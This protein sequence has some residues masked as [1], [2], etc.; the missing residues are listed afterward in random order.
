[1][2]YIK[3]KRQMSYQQLAIL[4]Q[5]ATASFG[6]PLPDS[7]RRIFIAS[8]GELLNNDAQY[9]LEQ[10]GNELQSLMMKFLMV[11]KALDW[12]DRVDEVRLAV[13]RKDTGCRSNA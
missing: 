4:Y 8:I 5:Q 9:M 12:S 1:M 3:G 11:K 6:L 13:I 10:A 7:V 2:Q